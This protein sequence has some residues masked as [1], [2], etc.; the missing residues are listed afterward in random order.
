MV[1]LRLARENIRYFHLWDE[2]TLPTIPPRLIVDYNSSQPQFGDQYE[3]TA[4][5]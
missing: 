4:S 2:K 3:N 1:L 5:L